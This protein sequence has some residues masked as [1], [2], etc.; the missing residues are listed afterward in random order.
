MTRIR[1]NVIAKII[2][3]GMVV[4]ANRNGV[5]QSNTLNPTMATEKGCWK[6]GNPTFLPGFQ[7][8]DYSIGIPHPI[9]MMG[10]NSHVCSRTTLRDYVIGVDRERF[11]NQGR[12]IT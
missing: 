2:T 12:V 5:W 8:L 11:R 6:N 9:K 10:A 4:E 3:L 1:G 7:L